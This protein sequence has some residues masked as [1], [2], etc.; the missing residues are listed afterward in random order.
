MLGIFKLYHRLLEAGQ[1][2]PPLV[3]RLILGWMFLE[4]GRGKLADLSGPISYFKSLGIPFAEYQ[5]PMVAGLELGCGAL[6]IAGL[7]TRVSAT[8]LAGIMVVATLT[9]KASELKVETFTDWPGTLWA[10]P[11]ALTVL[12][13]LYLMCYGAGL[14]S[15]DAIAVKL[16]KG[17]GSKPKSGGDDKPEKKPK[18]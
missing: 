15:L 8:L 12:L 9:A 11:E 7:L 18:K 17:G 6:L 2:L 1:F 5:A 3:T 14:L 13:C 16:G 4:S 10:I